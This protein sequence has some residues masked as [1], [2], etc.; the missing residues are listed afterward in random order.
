MMRTVVLGATGQLG[1]EVVKALV[2]RKY[3][4]KSSG[5]TASDA[6]TRQLG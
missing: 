5:T 3:T 1:R 6:C 4:V 2:N